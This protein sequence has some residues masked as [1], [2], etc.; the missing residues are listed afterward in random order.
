MCY[1]TKKNYTEHTKYNSKSIPCLL[2][3][4]KSEISIAIFFQKS[5][6]YRRKISAEEI[7][8]VISFT[9]QTKILQNKNKNRENKVYVLLS[10]PPTWQCLHY[11]YKQKYYKRNNRIEKILKFLLLCRQRLQLQSSPSKLPR[12]ESYHKETISFFSYLTSLPSSLATT[13]LGLNRQ[14]VP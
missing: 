6:V 14:K 2:F 12:S 4:N 9:M 1:S 5:K 7:Y 13:S 8:V 11:S 10:R 3:D